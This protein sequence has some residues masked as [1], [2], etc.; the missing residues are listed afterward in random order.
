[1]GLKLGQYEGCNLGIG[2]YVSELQL[3]LEALVEMVMA[4]TR[5]FIRI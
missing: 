2:L 5:P 4:C 3:C 1:M